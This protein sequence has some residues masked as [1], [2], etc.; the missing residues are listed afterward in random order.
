MIRTNFHSSNTL[1]AINFNVLAYTATGWTQAGVNARG[2]A[3][4]FS[5]DFW[6]SGS[7]PADHGF[8]NPP[9]YTPD[10]TRVSYRVF[11]FQVWGDFVIDSF[12]IL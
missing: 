10:F 5:V 3:T 6:F 1:Y 4:P 9:G 2:S 11:I 12:E 8:G 7:G